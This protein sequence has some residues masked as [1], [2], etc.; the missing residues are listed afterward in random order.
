M[1]DPNIINSININNSG[2]K[3]GRNTKEA[4][5]YKQLTVLKT[6]VLFLK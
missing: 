2:L 1:L 5:G 4:N 3:E 6:I